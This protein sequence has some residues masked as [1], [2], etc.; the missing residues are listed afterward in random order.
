MKN[1]P[2]TVIFDTDAGGGELVSGRPQSR[3]EEP[4]CC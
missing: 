1:A 2:G 3:T 4:T